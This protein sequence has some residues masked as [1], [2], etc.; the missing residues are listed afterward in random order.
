[1]VLSA[2]LH[3][4]CSQSIFLV[5]IHFN[6]SALENPDQTCNESISPLY[7]DPYACTSEYLSCGYSPVAIFSTICVGA[8]MLGF[9]LVIG[10]FRFKNGGMPVAG[11]CSAAISAACHSTGGD[12]LGESKMQRGDRLGLHK[13]PLLASEEAEEGGSLEAGELDAACRPVQWGD[14]GLYTEL[15]EGLAGVEVGAFSSDASLVQ[16]RRVGHCGFSSQKVGVPREGELYAGRPASHAR[17]T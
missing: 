15:A 8:A 13:V 7:D 10:C 5:S 11:S 12:Q 2:V 6:H 3:W 9:L 14:M 1:M 4:L 16:R 17:E